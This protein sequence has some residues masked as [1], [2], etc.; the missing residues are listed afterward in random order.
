MTIEFNGFETI[1][2]TLAPERLDTACNRILDRSGAVWRD[3]TKKMPPVSA[4]RDGY[5]AKGM[6]VATGLTRQEIN[7]R[8]LQ[9]L[10]T[11]VFGGTYYSGF[12]Q[13]GTSRVP[14]RDFFAWALE[15]G[16]WEQ[17]QAIVAEELSHAI[18]A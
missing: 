4:T 12:V 18:D 16:V 7:A 17:I 2:R 9:D 1:Q 5:N 10:A 14:P 13:Q 3:G 8:R 11:G 15:L 6:P